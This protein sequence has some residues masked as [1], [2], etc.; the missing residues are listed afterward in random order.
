[1]AGPPGLGGQPLPPSVPSPRD[2]GDFLPAPRERSLSLPPELTV[3]GTRSPGH[4]G[5]LLFAR[6]EDTLPKLWPGRHTELCKP[7]SLSCH[8]LVTEPLPF[9]GHPERLPG[10]PSCPWEGMPGLWSGLSLPLGLG[11]MSPAPRFS[12]QPRE[13]RWP[14]SLQHTQLFSLPCADWFPTGEC[15]PLRAGT[16]CVL[17]TA[18]GPAHSRCSIHI[19]WMRNEWVKDPLDCS[20]AGPSRAP[21]R[22]CGVALPAR[23][24]A[25]AKVSCVLVAPAGAWSVIPTLGQV[26]L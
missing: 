22:E 24:G 14:L 18:Q 15:Q 25:P 7:P 4:S 10:Q 2:G 12:C 26:S 19:C 8:V 21:E 6:A 1:M 9:L 17:F 16:L 11:F 13:S 5:T 23:C 3:C 20:V